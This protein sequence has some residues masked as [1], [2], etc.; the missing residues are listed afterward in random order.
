MSHELLSKRVATLEA[1]ADTAHP[2]SPGPHGESLVMRSQLAELSSRL[3]SME[4]SRI[5]P[6][7]TISGIPA[8]ITDSPK[9]IVLRVFEAL[10]IPEPAVDVLSVRSLTR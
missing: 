8:P 2:D 6:D 9:T 7:I 1:R 5:S 10:G 4:S 3:P